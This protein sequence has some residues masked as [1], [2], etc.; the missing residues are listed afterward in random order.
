MAKT[1][2]DYEDYLYRVIATV[3][4]YSRKVVVLDY[5]SSPAKRSI[6]LI[7]ELLDGRRILAKVIYD[8]SMIS[9]REVAELSSIAHSLGVSAL[10]VADRIGDEEVLDGVVYDR[11]GVNLVNLETLEN[12]LSGRDQVYVSKYK[13]LYTANVSGD[14]LREKRL[15]SGL[16][17]GDVAFMLKTSRKSVYE[18]ERGY[19]APSVDKAEKLIEIFGDDILEPIDILASP[20]KPVSKV[21]YDTSEEAAIGEKLSEL[22]YK[23]SHAKRTVIDL[24]AGSSS[25]D[26]R[27]IIVIRRSR[28]SEERLASR[29]AKCDKASSILS[30]DVF[31]IISEDAPRAA[32]SLESDRVIAVRMRE[33][34]SRLSGGES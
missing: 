30:T 34:L 20:K 6:D 15:E 10:I 33:F 26:K 32:R 5:P 1:P 19:M 3:Y 13:D 17:L 8:A 11:Y 28:E 23:V 16:S 9:K 24:A 27:M 2:V 31:V 21:D 22:G 18:Y 7:V 25:G 14:R 4:R 29:L 12:Y